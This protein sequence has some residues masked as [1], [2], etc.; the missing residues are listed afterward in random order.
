M[1]LHPASL[2]LF[3]TMV[4]IALLPMESSEYSARIVSRNGAQKSH[5]LQWSDL[6]GDSISDLIGVY[7]N[8]TG[9]MAVYI[10]LYPSLYLHEWD[11]H[12][13][14]FAVNDHFVTTG[15]YDRDK[16]KEI[17]ALTWSNDSV[18][19]NIISDLRA[20]KPMVSDRFVC[21][22]G[23][24]KG[25]SDPR[26]LL[27]EMQDM[28]GDGFLEFIFGLSSG[29]SLHPRNL[30]SY[31][32]RKDSL[33]VSPPMGFS[34]H[35]I[36]P[37]QISPKQN[38]CFLLGGYAPGNISDQEHPLNDSS[39]W[40]VALDRHLNFLFP[41]YE[42]FGHSGS[43]YTFSV[44]VGNMNSRVGVIWQPPATLQ[45]AAQMDIFDTSGT[46]VKTRTIRNPVLLEGVLVQIPSRFAIDNQEL[47]F[48]NNYESCILVDSMLSVREI[49]PSASLGPDLHFLDINQDGFSEMIS[50]DPNTGFLS[51]FRSLKDK[52]VTLAL[53]LSEPNHTTY[54]LRRHQEGGSSLFI[55]S[56][57]YHYS[58]VYGVNTAY[59]TRWIIY[60]GIFL[61]FFSFALF[62]SR[63]QKN[64]ML[65][66]AATEKKITELQLAI[67]RNQLDPHFTLNAI[68]AV[69]EAVGREEKE[70]AR[71]N[72]LHF[73]KMYRSLLLS[74]DR[75]KRTLREEIEF[76]ESY[77]ALERFRFG[78][79]FEYRIDI[80][81]EV[82]P[83]TEVPKM[84]IQSAV[85]NAVKHGIR[86]RESGG[87]IRI[88]ATRE[89][90]SLTLEI[91]DNGP[92][93]AAA[94]AGGT[95]GTG[96]GIQSMEQFFDLY[97]KVTGVTVTA[98]V[99]DLEDAQGQPSGTLVRIV[100]R[101]D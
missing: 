2:A 45:R 64:R 95:S 86:L 26:I 99:T 14:R 28:D 40:F 41:P 54:S 20:K 57:G 16:R 49:K 21:K 10:R 32:I 60:A 43:T 82:D 75:I 12:G 72:L 50:A 47:I 19:L 63:I 80:G 97:R 44:P 87:Q 56:G 35:Q 71:E 90:R 76:T 9:T 34:F 74:A 4:I 85:E 13:K 88:A 73:S 48:R 51:I 22:L 91:S 58:I 94:R 36:C 70:A 67:V 37:V 62:V 100:I 17:Y 96:K 11:V 30:F 66:K 24:V 84:V 52:P 6:E 89:G 5:V 23:Q 42:Y 1:L 18:F 25:V 33:R 77:L 101:E 15:D 29:F 83:A 78:N 27:T 3:L 31:N 92:G 8:L 46:L 7:E 98:A 93:R 53:T 61:G 39:C 79:R 68:N 81:P 69:T 65:K 38:P 55:S 59:W